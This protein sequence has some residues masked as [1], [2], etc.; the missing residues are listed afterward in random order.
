MIRSLAVAV[1][2]IA[3]GPTGTAGTAGT[4]GVRRSGGTS[5]PDAPR[6]E[7]EVARARAIA[8][9]LRQAE[10][11]SADDPKA[12]DRELP[13]ELTR[14]RLDAIAVARDPDAREARLYATL[15][16]A[17]HH[18]AQQRREPAIALVDPIVAVTIG[19]LP[20]NLY[21]PELVA[22]V[23][24]RRAALAKR[25]VGTLDVACTHACQAVVEG[26]VMGCAGPDAPLHVQMPSGRWHIVVFDPIVPSH[27]ISTDVDLVGGGAA[28][29]HL[30]GRA[31]EGGSGAGADA[32]ARRLPR[33]AGIL[34]I[35]AGAA[36]MIAGSILVGVDGQCPDRATD[37]P[38][39]CDRLL[40]T[41]GI[42]Y[43]LLAGGAAISIGF[44]IPLGIGETRLR[45]RG[46]R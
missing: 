30:G 3:A 32:S 43:G 36:L 23:A 37:G 24:E 40:N 1:S 5:C 16:L 44:A 6:T 41:G 19:E 28:K 22:F 11:R 39:P 46:R 42:G 2:V 21:G 7:A 18:L 20:I 9:S 15:A 31:G 17:A 8:R 45:R 33:W 25:E 29:L 14:A 12:G 38:N 35:S 10:S 13:T 26:V 34:G 4:L 27:S